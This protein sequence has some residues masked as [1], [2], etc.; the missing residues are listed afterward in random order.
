MS[1]YLERNSQAS[2][3]HPSEVQFAVSV[4]PPPQKIRFRSAVSP[5]Q[6]SENG[7]QCGRIRDGLDKKE[8]TKERRGE[9]D[10][11]SAPRVRRSPRA[12]TSGRIS[13]KDRA[14]PGVELSGGA[15]SFVKELGCSLA[16]P[17]SHC[18][19]QRSVGLSSV[20]KAQ[21]TRRHAFLV[22]S[23]NPVVVL[24]FK[25]KIL[26]P[27]TIF[28]KICQCPCCEFPESF[29]PYHGL[30]GRILQGCQC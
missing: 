28:S 27:C 11:R 19:V 14:V 21:I 15:S 23:H 24:S 9:E 8:N 6:V 13:H 22:S 18:R 7:E 29:M 26:F 3:S 25:P 17:P 2:T 1:T 5:S 10:R 30:F 20:W 4:T 16:L 12:I